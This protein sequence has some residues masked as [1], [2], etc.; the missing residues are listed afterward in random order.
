MPDRYSSLQKT[1]HFIEGFAYAKERG[2]KPQSIQYFDQYLYHLKNAVDTQEMNEALSEYYQDLM[3]YYDLCKKAGEVYGTATKEERDNLLKEASAKADTITEH[4]NKTGFYTHPEIVEA[5]KANNDQNPNLCSLY[6]GFWVKD[7]VFRGESVLA[8]AGAQKSAAKWIDGFKKEIK[9]GQPVSEDTV[10]K[11]LA[12]RQLANA[13]LG[14]RKNIDDKKLT[15]AEI[16]AQ[17]YKLKNSSEFKEFVKQNQPFDPALVTDGHGGKFEKSFEDFLVKMKPAEEMDFDAHGRYTKRIND[18]IK[19]TADFEILENPFRKKEEP[20]KEPGWAPGKEGSPKYPYKT[21]REYFNLNKTNLDGTVTPEYHAAKMAAAD[22]FSRK[23]PDAQFKDA[24]LREKAKDFMEDPGF[25]IVCKVPGAMDMI[26]KGDVEGFSK[27]VDALNNSCE[28]MLD[29]EGTFDPKGYIYLS[30]DR[31][32]EFLDKN[33]DKDLKKVIDKYNALHDGE[34]KHDAKEVLNVITA[35]TD[36]QDKYAHVTDSK[37]EENVN[38]TL[39]LLYEMT[40]KRSI[41]SIVE[42]QIDKIN[43]SRGIRKGEKGYLTKDIISAEGK[44]EAE[45]IKKAVVNG[46]RFK[47]E[48]DLN[49]SVDSKKTDVEKVNEELN[50]SFNFGNGLNI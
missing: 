35:I 21:Y 26:C 30:R 18:N 23:D 45:K 25:K 42:T 48:Q 16:D 40:A 20:K 34:A 13:I 11:I 4:I 7:T 22:H 36:Y 49:K 29:D 50:K 8:G 39:K 19:A 3:A 28:A 37:T 46:D 17:V 15:Q 6:E 1:A 27:E 24:E 32:E 47:D 12:S 10:A 41:G 14:K 5:A 43:K 9:K 44:D 38:D 2:A 31:L 33:D